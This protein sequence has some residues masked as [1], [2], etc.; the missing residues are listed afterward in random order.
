MPPGTEIQKTGLVLGKRGGVISLFK[1]LR[2]PFKKG[3]RKSFWLDNEAD[4]EY[5]YKD[6]TEKVNEKLMDLHPDHGGD[7]KLFREFRDQ[8]NLVKKMFHNKGIGGVDPLIK[9]LRLES[10]KP[11]KKVKQKVTLRITHGRFNRGTPC[12]EILERLR[13]GRSARRI[14]SELGTTKETIRKVKHLLS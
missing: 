3:R 4:L 1:A 2:I 14:A 7:P 10:S 6:L 9:A 13:Q 12:N 5:L 8:S 11:Q